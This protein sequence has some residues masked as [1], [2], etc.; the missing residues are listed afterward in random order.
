MKIAYIITLPD[1]G[2]AQSHVYELMKNIRISYDVEPI[3]ITGRKGWLTKKAAELQIETHI[4]PDL[5]REI[6]PVHDFKANLAIQR[7]LREIQP[8]LVHCHSSKAGILGRWA[9][10]RCHIPSVFTAHGW[11]F[12]DGV[13]ERKRKIYRMIEKMAGAWCQKIICVSDYDRNL[14]LREIPE[15]RDELITVHNCIPDTPYQKDWTQYDASS[16]LS[17]I[18]VA[19]FSPQKKNKEIL[20]VLSLAL[21][22]GLDI[23][24]TFVGT[25]PEFDETKEYAAR[26]GLNKNVIFLGARSD[27]EQ[28]L[29]KYDLFLLLSNW[30]GFPISII[31]AMRAGLPVMA[32]NVGGVAESVKDNINGW[33]IPRDDSNIV[34]TFQAL[35]ENPGMIS[36]L[37]RTAREMYEKKYQVGL[38]TEV[39]HKIYDNLAQTEEENISLRGGLSLFYFEDLVLLPE[40]QGS[41]CA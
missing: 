33:L 8:D 39:I 28:L 17:V 13:P 7:L 9:A 1:L 18:T 23:H 12:T 14:A 41:L 22:R 5:V 36:R 2:G 15:L 11:A 20:R 27:V 35:K 32:S 34:E 16:P 19:R 6:S 26:L 40:Q 29:P 37:G 30:E 4:V 24:I 3:L 31:E 10:K 38:M 21:E 25:G